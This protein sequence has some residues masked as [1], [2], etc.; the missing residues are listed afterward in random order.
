[1]FWGKLQNVTLRKSSILYISSVLGTA[2]LDHSVR[3]RVPIRRRA[4]TY[5]HVR[6]A[7]GAHYSQQR[8]TNELTIMMMMMMKYV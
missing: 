7:S 2:F 6:Y 4:Q 5:V 8:I 3:I 1:V